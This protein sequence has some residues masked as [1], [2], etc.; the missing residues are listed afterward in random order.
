MTTYAKFFKNKYLNF[1][2][3]FCQILVHMVGFENAWNQAYLTTSVSGSSSMNNQKGGVGGGGPNSQ[4]K[5]S[6]ISSSQPMN[7]A[8]NNA[9]QNKIKIDLVLFY[10]NFFEYPCVPKPSVFQT[11]TT[12][13]NWTAMLQILH[14][15][16]NIVKVGRFL[17]IKFFSSNC[18]YK[19][20]FLLV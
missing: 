8:Q 16:A 15:F 4:N 9:Q 13:K 18:C 14:Y 2:V 11:M 20:F 1:F 6:G 10:L 7:Q 5:G 19:P 3:I 17:S 12:P